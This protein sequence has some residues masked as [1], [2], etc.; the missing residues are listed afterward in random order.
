MGHYELD[1]TL[2]GDFTRPGLADLLDLLRL[3]VVHRG[4]GWPEFWVP[5]RAEIEP[6]VI[7]NTIQ[8]WLGTPDMG[9]R[10]T[11]HVDFWRA[12]PEGRMFLLRG[13]FE[14]KGGWSGQSIEPGTIIDIGAPVGRVAECLSTRATL[15]RSLLLTKTLR[16]SSERVG[17]ACA[18][19]DLAR[20]IDGERSRCMMTALPGKMS[21][22]SKQRLR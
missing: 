13:Y 20:L 16:C 6:C 1:Y 7:D 21:L 8:C 3:A 14:D 15:V 10:D 18:D 2:L 11:A 5:T 19:D 12:S 22:R 4:G 17:T 9:P